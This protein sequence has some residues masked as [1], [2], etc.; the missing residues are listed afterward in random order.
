MSSRVVQEA[1]K[2]RASLALYARLLSYIH[3]EWRPLVLT[4]LAMLGTT[5]LAL[6]RPWP[7]QVIVDS[8]LGDQ[9]PPWWLTAPLGTLPTR[10]LLAAAIGLMVVVL[11]VGVGFSL[12][13]QY[14][15][16]SLGQRMVLRLRYDLYAKLQ[17]LSLRFHDHSSLGDLIFRITGDAAALQDIVVYGFVPFAIQLTAVAAIA[18]TIFVL[19]VRLGLIAVAIVPLLFLWTGW[20]SERVR[21]RSRLLAGADSKLY[22]TVSETLGAIRA[23]KSFAMEEVEL[24]RFR[25][26]A[27]SSQEAYVGVMTLSTVGGLV[28]D[29][30]AGLGTAAVVYLAALTVLDGRLTVG[31]LL[32]FVAYL[33]SLYAPISQ[34]AGSAMVVQRSAASI[35]RV[36]E[37]LDQQDEHTEA[38]TGTL[39]RVAGHVSYDHVVMGYQADSTVLRGVSLNV[40]PG[41]MVAFVGRSGAGKTTLVSLLLGFYRPR[42]GNVR[43]D[44]TP[45]D[46]L[47]VTWLRQQIALVLQEPIIFSCSLG[48]NIAYGRPEATPAEIVRASEAAGLHEFVSDL[49]DGYD[50]EVGERGVRLSGG[51]RQRV[52]IARAFLKD[53]PILVLDEP[54]SN[55]DATTEQHIF[56]SLDRLAR[57]RTTLVISHRLATVRRADRIVVLADGQ[58]VEEGTHD[59]LLAAHGA[60]ARLYSDQMDAAHSRRVAGR[61]QG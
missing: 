52:S 3:A 57:G 50:T 28:T 1:R 55:L 53:A 42:S 2:L 54:T 41:E 39:P 40:V 30:I 20:F 16:Q 37:I 22:T 38:G 36:V 61:T 51:Q 44:G 5:A 23:V 49:P 34:L 7:M 17:R 18:G 11:L 32:V 21:R 35:E 8:V 31:Q 13:Q 43:L 15:S 4:V 25:R 60:Y 46:S 56:A 59:A 47:D 33:Q 19:D 10:Q 14:F 29:A 45:I 9:A 27:Q 48:E 24:A 6:A 58:I 12:A 26:H